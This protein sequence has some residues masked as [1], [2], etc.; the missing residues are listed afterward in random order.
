MLKLTKVAKKD[1]MGARE[2]GS[3]GAREQGSKG[4]R[5][6][7]EQGGQGNKGAREQGRKGAREHSVV[8]RS[9]YR[10]RESIACISPLTQV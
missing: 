4:A 5:G 8:Y 6:A 7:R 9:W 2:Q 3:K 1:S 10:H